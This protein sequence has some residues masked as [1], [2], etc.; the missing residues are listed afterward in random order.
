[1]CHEDIILFFFD[2]N[3]MS[4]ELQLKETTAQCVHCEVQLAYRG[5]TTSMSQQFNC[6]PLHASTPPSLGDANAV[7][8]TNRCDGCFRGMHLNKNI[9]YGYM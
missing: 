9:N 2:K 7:M 3:N 1:M 4:Y 5:S 8:A 6:K